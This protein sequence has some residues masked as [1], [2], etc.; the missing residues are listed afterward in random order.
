MGGP[1]S[2]SLGGKSS[3]G[4]HLSF[5]APGEAAVSQCTALRRDTVLLLSIAEKV[6][7]GL[8]WT[9]RSGGHL[10]PTADRRSLGLREG[11]GRWTM[12]LGGDQEGDQSQSDPGML[13]MA[14]S[15]GVSR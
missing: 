5:S 10:C 14:P 9:L 11:T 12:G 13:C 6:S 8:C 1:I 4:Y 3:A 7:P 15:P 2:R